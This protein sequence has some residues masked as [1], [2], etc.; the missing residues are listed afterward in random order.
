MSRQVTSISGGAGQ[1]PI[2]SFFSSLGRSLKLALVLVLA[3]LAWMAWCFQHPTP[4]SVTAAAPMP[5]GFL[6]G[7]SS[8]AFQSEG[9]RIDS[10][11][12]DFNAAE[13]K[14][15][16][17][18]KSVDFRHRYRED[19]ALAR[20]LGVNTYRIGINWARVEPSPG[21]STRW[22]SPIMTISSSR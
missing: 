14:H 8:S 15:D 10:V 13:K 21:R 20:D 9:G 18:G 17:Y 1:L 11:W 5:P 4:L 2:I 22:N 7:V 3:L 6:W 12:S 16:R 19:V